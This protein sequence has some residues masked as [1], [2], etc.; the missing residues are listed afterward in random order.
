KDSL[1]CF[2][3]TFKLFVDVGIKENSLDAALK[4]Y[5]NPA[6]DYLSIDF[7]ATETIKEIK[8][9][10]VTGSQKKSDYQIQNNKLIINVSALSG[11]AYVLRIETLNGIRSQKVI[12]SK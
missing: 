9:L 10:D 5:P 2:A 6:E 11:G 4:I 8:I 7:D 1:N 12:I 3:D